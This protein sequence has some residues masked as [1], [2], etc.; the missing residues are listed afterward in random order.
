MLCSSNPARAQL[1]LL[2]L[3]RSGMRARDRRNSD[4][5]LWDE[6]DVRRSLGSTAGRAGRFAEDGAPVREAAHRYAHS[7]VRMRSRARARACVHANVRLHARTCVACVHA[8]S[9][10]AP[11][12]PAYCLPVSVILCAR[13][14]A[15]VC[16]CARGERV[17][18]LHVY[19]RRAESA[20]S[21]GTTYRCTT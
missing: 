2:A 6:C 8:R 14:R 9:F 12:W 21:R 18:W 16:K 13:E 4:T 7:G 5:R 1:A 20:Q 11:P 17:C 19:T 15:C 3:R 10:C